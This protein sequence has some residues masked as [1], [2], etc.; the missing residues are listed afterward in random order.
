MGWFVYYTV[1]G[2]TAWCIACL[3]LLTPFWLYVPVKRKGKE[4]EKDLNGQVIE[5]NIICYGNDMLVC[6]LFVSCV[7]YFVVNH[8]SLH[9]IETIFWSVV[10]PGFF[11][12]VDILLHWIPLIDG[13]PPTLMRKV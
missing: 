7:V 12:C 13:E 6:D 1:V 11:S 3:Q 5:H 10:R 4:R 8:L 2:R 9:Y